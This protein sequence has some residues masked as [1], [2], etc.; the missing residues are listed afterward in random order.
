MVRILKILV[1][2]CKMVMHTYIHGETSTDRKP[3]AARPAEERAEK[4]NPVWPTLAV[5]PPALQ[6]KLKISQPGDA[7]EE[8]AD[9]IAARVMRMADVSSRLQESEPLDVD[10]AYAKLSRVTSLPQATPPEIKDLLGCE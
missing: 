4:S 7:Y 2:A 10:P 6:P 8:E 9:Q 1:S 5:R 3:P